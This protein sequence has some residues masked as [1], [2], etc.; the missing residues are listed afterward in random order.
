V[1]AFQ[2]EDRAAAEDDPQA[3]RLVGVAGRICFSRRRSEM[4]VKRLGRVFIGC[5][6]MIGGLAACSGASSTAPGGG[7]PA[8]SPSFTGTV[9]TVSINAGGPATGGFWADQFFSGGATYGNAATIDMSQITSS[10]PPA[11]IFNTERYGAMTYTIPDR[12]GAQMVTLYF[13]ETYVSGPGQRLFDV[14]I[15]GAR[16]LSSFDIYA[17]AGGANRAIARTVVTTADSSG[18]VVIQFITGTQN[19]KINGITVTGGGTTVTPPPPTPTPPPAA[20]PTNRGDEKASAGCGKTRTLQNGTIGIESNGTRSYILRAPDN[21]D[22]NHPYRLV[23]AYHWMSGTAQDVAEGSGPSET[24]FYGLRDLAN[25]STIFVAPMGRGSG[26]NTGWANAGGEDV[27]FT[28]AIL[29]QVEAA[30]CIDTTRIFA[31]GFSYGAGMSYAVACARP[32][33]FRGVALYSGALLS[34]C[35]GGTKPIAFYAS[36]GLSDSVLDISAGRILRDHFVE[37][38]GVTP[39]N[40]PEP[41]IGSGTHICTKYQGGSPQYPVVWCAFDGDHT[42]NPHDSGQGTSW[43]PPEVWDFI[44]QF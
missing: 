15:N 11:A 23:I 17:S 27:A 16:V 35:D 26:Q 37:V 5:V 8:P 20:P 31:T 14:A 24:V 33:V 4:Q 34:G 10:Q 7:T 36:H 12:S 29:A 22:P 25:N 6:F 41:D 13:A 32:D 42:P 38:N 18:Q 9:S 2:A 44:S 3:V 39:Q 28:D 43:N 1:P 30:L 21:Y 19:P 40:P